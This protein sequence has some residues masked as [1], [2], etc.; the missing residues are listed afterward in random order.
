VALP[1]MAHTKP[2]VKYVK[3]LAN[4]RDFSYLHTV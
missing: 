3:S 1:T 2:K 4:V